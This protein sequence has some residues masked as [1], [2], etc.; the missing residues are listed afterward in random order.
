MEKIRKSEKKQNTLMETTFNQTQVAS[1]YMQG[2]TQK[3][4][5]DKVGCSIATVRRHMESLREEW[6]NRSLYDFSRAKAEQLAKVDEVERVAW[7]QFS[8]SA[9][10]ESLTEFLDANDLVTSQIKNTSKNAQE[11]KWLEKIQ[12]CIDQRC[13]ILGLYAPKQQII[14]Q[15]ISDSRNLEDMTTDELLKIANKTQI[16]AEFH[17]VSDVVEMGTEEG[18][19]DLTDE[20]VSQRD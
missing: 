8:L 18:E 12:W 4:I 14:Q 17:D 10:R 11:I 19:V 3:V 16:P 13:K 9:S 20:L 15:N 5:S 1:F 2:L 7:E 6:M